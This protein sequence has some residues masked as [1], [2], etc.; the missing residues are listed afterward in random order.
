[1]IFKY[2]DE[3]TVSNSLAVFVYYKKT[4]GNSLE[5]DLTKLN[6][7][8]KQLENADELTSE[9]IE[10]LYNN[11]DPTET[12][13]NI[14][15]SMRCAGE[16]QQLDYI[17]TIAEIGASDLVDGS[18]NILIERLV[19]VKKNNQVNQQVHIKK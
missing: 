16:E 8:A 9:Q 19:D 12:L 2:K 6:A 10:H 14:Y 17:K 3:Y 4:T 18:L 1:M 13:C 5:R 11:V 15:Y 7:V